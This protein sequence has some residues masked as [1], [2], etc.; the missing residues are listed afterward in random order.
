MPGKNWA[1][2]LLAMLANRRTI[3]KLE[4]YSGFYASHLHCLTALVSGCL[5]V[6]RTRLHARDSHGHTTSNA[7]CTDH[8]GSMLGARR[9]VYA[10]E[11]CL[12]RHT[13]TLP[14]AYSGYDDVSHFAKVTRT[15]SRFMTL[16]LTSEGSQSHNSPLRPICPS[17]KE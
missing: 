9:R 17:W 14:Q 12:C 5:Q 16:C 11:T 7:V 8:L 6:L 10:P 13:G 2:G 1:I 15:I 3:P 4:L